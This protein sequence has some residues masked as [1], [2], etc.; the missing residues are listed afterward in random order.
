MHPAPVWE[1]CTRHADARWRQ[2]TE[3]VQELS[4]LQS[5]L[6]SQTSASEPGG[7]LVYATCTL[8]P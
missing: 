5:Q 7:V 1:L 8:H 2:T 4:V 6:L 3:S